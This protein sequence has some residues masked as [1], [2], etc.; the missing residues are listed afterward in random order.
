MYWDSIIFSRGALDV[1]ASTINERMKLAAV[2]AIANLAKEAVRKAVILA[3]NL[4]SLTFGRIFH[5]NLST[6]GSL[7]VCQCDRQSRHR[8]R[9]CRKAD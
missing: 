9:C 7:R 4:T 6:T 3:Y 2:H 5:Q 8:Q 1:Q